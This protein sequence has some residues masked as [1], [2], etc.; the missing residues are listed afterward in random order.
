[1][2]R[3]PEARVVPS[4][5]FS[6]TG[7]D[8]AG[9]VYIKVGLRKTVRVKAYICIFVCLAVKAIHLEL[10]SDLSSAA[11]IAALQRFVSRSRN[12]LCRSAFAS[13][14]RKQSKAKTTMSEATT[15]TDYWGWQLLPKASAKK[16]IA[17][18]IGNSQ[19]IHETITIPKR[20]HAWDDV[21]MIRRL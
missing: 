4:I 17:S 14:N 7:V 18:R 5:P 1:M 11:I 21:Y 10:V 8:F 19:A 13:A 9:P 20:S 3:L 2:G 15:T 16:A 6:R 12:K